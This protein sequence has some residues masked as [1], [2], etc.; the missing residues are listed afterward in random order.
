VR[1]AGARFGLA[2]GTGPG[3][4]A[5]PD[6]YWSPPKAQIRIRIGMGTPSSHNR[7]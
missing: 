7:M 5:P 2:L 1:T 4:R 6:V 3:Q